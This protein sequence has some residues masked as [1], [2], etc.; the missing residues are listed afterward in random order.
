MGKMTIQQGKLTGGT[1][2]DRE[3]GAMVESTSNQA[4]K[5]KMEPPEGA[6]SSS[7]CSRWNGCGPVTEDHRQTRRSGEGEVI[8]MLVRRA[9]TK[10]LNI[11]YFVG[12]RFRMK[13]TGAAT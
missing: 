13:L 9:T 12:N 11:P 7:M 4:M 2:F 6:P 10:A 8:Q 3:L 1:S 5:F